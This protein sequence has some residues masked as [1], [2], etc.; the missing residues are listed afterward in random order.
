MKIMKAIDVKFLIFVKLKNSYRLY[1]EDIRIIILILNCKCWVF[2]FTL[3]S[4]NKEEEI[5]IPKNLE[6]KIW[7]NGLIIFNF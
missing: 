7:E 3:W 6:W 4:A 2:K 5:K 1:L